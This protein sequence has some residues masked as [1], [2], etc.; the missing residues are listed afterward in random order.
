MNFTIEAY[1]FPIRLLVPLQ[2]DRSGTGEGDTNSG[3]TSQPSNYG[4]SVCLGICDGAK[5]TRLLIEAVNIEKMCLE[6]EYEVNE[7][8]LVLG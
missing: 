6:T 8:V 4:L 2:Q 7:N 1:P 3:V 5:Y